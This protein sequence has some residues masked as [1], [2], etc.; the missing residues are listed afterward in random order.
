MRGGNE[1][2]GVSGWMEN[3]EM[4]LSHSELVC[5]ADY[6]LG[7]SADLGLEPKEE[8]QEEE[9]Q[10][11]AAEKLSCGEPPDFCLALHTGRLCAECAEGAYKMPT[12]R[13]CQL[14]SWWA[15]I[16]TALICILIGVVI[17]R[18]ARPVSA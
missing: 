5:P 1:K 2:A 12:G 11:E 18:A 9:E 10:V 6:C 3:V 7:W 4:A 13:C 16:A 15:A 14:G 8:D 17:S